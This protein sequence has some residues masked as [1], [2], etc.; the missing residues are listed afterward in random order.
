MI[1]N[2]NGINMISFSSEVAFCE[3]GSFNKY[4]KIDFAWYTD[5]INSFNY[6]R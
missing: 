2:E 5:E 1:D 4:Q 3:C 6:Q